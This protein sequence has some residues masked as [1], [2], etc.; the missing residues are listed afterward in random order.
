MTDILTNGL[1]LR[2]VVQSLIFD[3]SRSLQ[4]VSTSTIT[5]CCHSLLRVS[6]KSILQ[7]ETAMLTDFRVSRRSI[8]VLC[9][10]TSFFTFV[11]CHLSLSRE[12]KAKYGGIMC[13]LPAFRIV[14]RYWYRKTRRRY[15][16]RMNPLSLQDSE[17]NL[18]TR[19]CE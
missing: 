12:E 2:Y 11:H 18:T 8:L 4:R 5:K 6:W 13:N 19:D 7:A 1:L 15:H 17:A 10:L 16:S 3:V 14:E 9:N